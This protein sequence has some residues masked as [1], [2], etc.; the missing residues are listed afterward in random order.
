MS[1]G[2]SHSSPD[3]QFSLDKGLFASL[4]RWKS[5]NVYSSILLWTVFMPVSHLQSFVYL[6]GL[7][8]CRR[9]ALQQILGICPRHMI[10]QEDLGP[11][12]T[13]HGAEPGAW[14]QIPAPSITSDVA[15]G[16]LFNLSICKNE[17]YT[18]IIWNVKIIIKTLVA[19]TPDSVIVRVK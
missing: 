1:E 18:T 3:S 13:G 10:K 16:K 6:N 5:I 15:L 7:V 8:Y 14:V 9:L 4:F 12:A 17:D 2:I 11:K 19:I